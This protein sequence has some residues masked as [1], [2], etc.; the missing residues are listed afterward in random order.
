MHQHGSKKRI[1]LSIATTMR[2][3]LVKYELTPEYYCEPFCGTLGLYQYVPPLFD[4]VSPDITYLAGDINESLIKMWKG[5]QK[6]TWTPPTSISKSKF[7]SLY[8]SGASADKGFIGHQC[9]FGG[10]YFGHYTPEFCTKKALTRA[11]EKVL[12]V[13]DALPPIKFSHGLY[14]QY[15]K[16]RKAV[17]YCDPPYSKYNRYYDED[18]NRLTFDHEAFWDWVRKMSKHNLVFVS[19]YSAPPDFTNIHSRKT[20]SHGRSANT[21]KLF[22]YDPK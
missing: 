10:I 19:E 16:L 3:F 4:E 14:T 22:I 18:H 1:G 7:D 12:S 13:I 17:I 20:K 9:A 15:S 2:D 5:A 21:E 8:K 11:G 6:G